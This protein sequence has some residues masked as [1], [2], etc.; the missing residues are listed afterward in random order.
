MKPVDV[1]S[2]PCIDIGTK[3]NDTDSKFKVDDNVTISKNKNI[4]VKG[5]VS[6][7][8]ESVFIIK[9]VKNTVLWACTISDLHSENIVE[10]CYKK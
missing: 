7:W 5:Y 3:N 10:T 8:S 1:K 4:F 2:S 6:N 9:K